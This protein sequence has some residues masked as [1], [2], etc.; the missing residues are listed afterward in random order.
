MKDMT[1]QKFENFKVIEFAYSEKG[2][3]FWKC[4]C[5]CGNVFVANGNHIRTHHTNSCGCL[6]NKK[7]L[8]RYEFENEIGICYF[9]RGGFFIFDKEDYEKIKDYTWSN[10]GDYASNIDS[11]GNCVLAHRLIL[12]PAKDL[13]V[14]HINH[15]PLDNRKCN[16]RIC[17]NQQNQY[18]RKSKGYYK[19]ENRY[20]VRL[21]NKYIGSCKTEEEAIEMRRK[22]ERE[23]YGEFAYKEVEN[24]S[25]ES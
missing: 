22:S 20:E 7:R 8:N 21:R 14:D 2:N 5:N 15:N 25:K 12:N 9:N 17:T 16:L 10:S 24:D 23:N 6:K 19:V 13:F 11:N 3:A 4:K 18:N 1:G